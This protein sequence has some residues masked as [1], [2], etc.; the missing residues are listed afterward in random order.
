MYT[1]TDNFAHIWNPLQL[2]SRCIHQRID[3]LKMI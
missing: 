1:R 3:A 2:V